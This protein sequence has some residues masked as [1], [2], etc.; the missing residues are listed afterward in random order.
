MSSRQVSLL[1]AASEHSNAGESGQGSSNRAPLAERMR[2][3]TLDEVLGQEKAVGPNSA[4]GQ[5]LRDADLAIPS[6]LLWGPP[7]VGKTTIARVIAANSNYRFVRL[8][9]VLDGVKELR[10][11]VADAEAALQRE[12]RNTLALVDEIHRFNKSQQ[13]AFLPH[14]ESGLLTVIGQT[15]DNVSFRIRNALL[16]R[17]RVIPLELLSV[18]VL[19]SLIER[20]LRDEERGLGK[21]QLTIDP[22]ARRTLSLLAGGDA[23]RALNGLEWAA[24]S[25]RADGAQ[26]ITQV[27]IEESFGSQPQRFDQDGDYHYDC[28]SA[29]IKSMRGSDP[30]AALYYM[31]RAL[32]GGEDP[33]FLTRRMIIFASEDASCDPR[34]LEVAINVDRAV[35][36]VGLP[37]GRI[38]LAQAAVYLACCAKSNA[39]YVA[40]RAMEK[41]IT[42][43]PELEIPKHLRNAPTELMREMG[44]SIGYQYPHDAPGGFV[45]MRY[46]PEALGDLRVYHP[47]D[48]ALD[49]QIRER[50]SH[51]EALIAETSAQSQKFGT[52]MASSSAASC[53]K[54]GTSRAS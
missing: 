13:D 1:G 28:V 26:C 22:A 3:R 17:M 7:G 47:T 39:S 45:P 30:D 53:T 9:G 4:F 12:G 27:T 32:E 10:A 46:L 6:V 18:D 50:L 34:A 38:P 19:E 54:F 31:L 51:Y 36:R 16:S 25:V 23:R 15:T 49:L 37:E 42:E 52:Q 11:A 43:H 44:N 20:A 29:F 24:A 2:P 21:W 14:V 5:I 33:L 40:L 41:V 8:S 48:R 35:E